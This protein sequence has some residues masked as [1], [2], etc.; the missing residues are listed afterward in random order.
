MLIGLVAGVAVLYALAYRFYAGWIGRQ[1]G[2]D[3]ARPTP[4]HTMK[5]GVDYVPTHDMILF[6]H[7]FSTI[8][9]AGP[10]V[11]PVIAALAFG[12]L[13]AVLWIAFG[14]VLIGGVHDFCVMVASIRN[15]GRSI[16]QIA[17]GFLS[18]TA[19]YIF[20]VFI[21]FTLVYVVIVFLDLTASTF[22]PAAAAAHAEGSE[23]VMLNAKQGG[24][25]ATASLLYIALALLFG[26]SIYRLRMPIWAGTLVFVPLVFG[27]LWLGSVFPITADLVP[28]FLG[29]AKNAWCLALLFYCLLAAMLPV[30]ILLQPRDYLSSFLLYACLLGGGVGLAA[31]SFAGK[32]A[33]AYPAFL[34][35]TS[36][37]K[38]CLFPTLFVTIACGAVSGF[39]AIVSSGTS[40]K[41]LRIETSARTIGYGG[42]L[43]EGILAMLA[44]ATV[45]ILAARPAGETP[46][47]TF[48]RGLGSFMETLGLSPG[49]A[50]TFAMMAVSTFLL[51]TLDSCTR[52]ARFIVAEIF[53]LSN[54]FVPRLLA[55]L[56]VLVP[57][58]LVV[59]RQIRD[60][61]GNLVPAWQAIWPAFGA[62]NQLLAALALLVVYSWLRHAGRRT[63]FVLAPML[64]MCATTLTALAQ[65][66]WRHT[67]SHWFAGGKAGSP[68]VGGVSLVLFILAVM[69]LANTVWL[70]VTKRT[71]SKAAS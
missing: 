36:A 58:A 68:F 55:T 67:G 47:V 16:G 33:I 41:Q 22:L 35:F 20:L 51:T 9:G 24:T 34:G 6:G 12:W 7:H 57:P 54:R 15:Q 53:Q 26:V 49:F 11:G 18:P 63:V 21:L 70:Q 32:A 42:M 65:L 37:S 60:V 46:V 50:S 66:F 39:H 59:F 13:P 56:A 25:V 14:A 30:W 8:A 69:V 27:A 52:L 2:L 29:S 1:V 31:T 48:G 5:D 10:I 61:N 23:Q 62:S 43:V 64:F 3:D 44:V 17:R 38:E 40:A 45:M 19:Y 4:A 71:T 28:A